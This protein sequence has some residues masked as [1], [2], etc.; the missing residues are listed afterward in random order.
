M[1]LS[2]CKESVLPLFMLHVHTHSKSSI[3]INVEGMY[4]PEDTQPLF[5]MGIL[6]GVHL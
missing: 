4:V 1:G 2:F 5:I 6:W 3:A